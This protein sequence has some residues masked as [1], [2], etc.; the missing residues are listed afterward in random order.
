MRTLVVIERCGQ[1]QPPWTHVRINMGTGFVMFLP[2]ARLDSGGPV[3]Q[4]RPTG[5]EDAI[6]LTHKAGLNFQI[7]AAGT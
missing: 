3:S 2:E 7:V 4:E 6:R 5:A 1:D